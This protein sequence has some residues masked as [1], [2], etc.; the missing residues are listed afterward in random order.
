MAGSG[1]RILLM[2]LRP[3]LRDIIVDALTN[4]ED[5]EFSL[6]ELGSERDLG[7]TSGDV[8]I[9]G[10][11]EPNKTEVPLRLLSKVPEMSVLMIAI[12]GETAA[13][14]Q[15]RPHRKSMGN[16]TAQGLIDAI[17]TSTVG[18]VTVLGPPQE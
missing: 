1:I 3:R 11:A 13:M 9:V 5:L 4:E 6:D 8:L 10:I 18:R 16:L 14:Y 2:N 12:T 7:Y 17:R 15:L